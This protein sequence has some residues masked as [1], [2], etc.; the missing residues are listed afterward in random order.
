MTYTILFL[1][2]LFIIYTII[3]FISSIYEELLQIF[4]KNYILN[5]VIYWHMVHIILTALCFKISYLKF[6]F[7]Y[8]TCISL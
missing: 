1:F 5:Y 8:D 3:L 6:I 4:L 7:I 2:L